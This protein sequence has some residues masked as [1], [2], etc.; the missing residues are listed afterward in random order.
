[1]PRRATPSPARPTGILRRFRRS[2]SGVSAVEFALIAP[3]MIV[4][5]LGGYELTEGVTISR[6]VTHVTSV[7][8][9]LVAQSE[10]IS[11]DEMID[12]F[13]AAE[14]V[15]NP[16]PTGEMELRIT[17]ISIDDD[18]AASVQWSCAQNTDPLTDEDEI[19][20]PADIN[21]DNTELVL[22]EV[23]YPYTPPFGQVVTGDLDLS[24]IFY[25]RPRF[26]AGVAGPDSC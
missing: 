11:S 19:I 2:A 12:V 25:L 5:Y 16:Y 4:L 17:A 1:M 21:E 23:H 26:A 9:D 10:Q 20:I 8:G 15:M 14:A 6:K 13:A 22:A 24:D 7:L 18:G 3:I